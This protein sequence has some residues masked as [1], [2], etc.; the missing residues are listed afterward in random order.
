MSPSPVRTRLALGNFLDALVTRIALLQTA[1]T[2]DRQTESHVQL[3]G[4]D[5]YL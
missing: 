3:S 4:K 2:D 1:P 5:A